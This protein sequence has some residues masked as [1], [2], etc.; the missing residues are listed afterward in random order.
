MSDYDNK[1]VILRKPEPRKPQNQ[2]A[3]FLH[4][5][6]EGKIIPSQVNHEF[7]RELQQARTGKKLTQ[8]QLAKQ[9]QIP[10]TVI[11][12]YENPN[13]GATVKQDYLQKIN[14]SLGV[15]LKKP[16]AKKLVPEEDKTNDK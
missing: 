10:V 14:R 6:E 12:D 5:I 3:Q 9:C 1:T 4:K 16:A 15:K 7:A 2:Q 13:S 8:D 11:K